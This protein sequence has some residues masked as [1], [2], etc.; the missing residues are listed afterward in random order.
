MRK[1]SSIK[2]CLDH[3]TNEE[4]QQAFELDGEDEENI[5]CK[6]TQPDYLKQIRKAI[7]KKHKKSGITA[8][9]PEQLQAYNYLLEKRRKSAPK[10]TLADNKQ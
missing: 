1:I 3:L 8:M 5:I 9:T 10:Q 4:I 7:A 6:F 2:Q